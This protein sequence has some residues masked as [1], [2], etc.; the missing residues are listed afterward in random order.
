M[1]AALVVEPDSEAPAPLDGKWTVATGG[2]N[3]SLMLVVEEG[4]LS[5]YTTGCSTTPETRPIAIG[6][7]SGG[8]FMF[9]TER[10]GGG[11]IWSGRYDPKQKA[12]LGRREH[13]ITGQLESFVARR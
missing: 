8:S 7:A 9:Q 13:V 12:L 4:D 6:L 3:C 1:D 11:W 2:V 10:A 5:G